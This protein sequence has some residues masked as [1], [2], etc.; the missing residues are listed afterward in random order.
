[1]YPVSSC[2]YNDVA[3]AAAM[4]PAH[5]RRRRRRRDH[6]NHSCEVTAT[7][8]LYRLRPDVRAMTAVAAAAHS[9]RDGSGEREAAG[10]RYNGDSQPGCSCPPP[11]GRTCVFK[12]WRFLESQN[13]DATIQTN[14][15]Y[16]TAVFSASMKPYR[17]TSLVKVVQAAPVSLPAATRDTYSTNRQPTGR[18]QVEVKGFQVN[19]H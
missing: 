13:V 17:G 9:S 14:T 7:G 19:R 3:A 1:M 12:T 8:W 18:R 2:C 15:K 4:Q 16:T 10:S 6:H 5:H 11:P